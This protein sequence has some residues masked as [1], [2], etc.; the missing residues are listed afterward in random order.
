MMR[1]RQLRAEQKRRNRMTVEYRPIVT[2]DRKRFR[3]ST[4]Q[5]REEE[6]ERAEQNKMAAMTDGI[7]ALEICANDRKIRLVQF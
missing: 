3:C 4:V 7:F 6:R 2:S 1:G 5:Q